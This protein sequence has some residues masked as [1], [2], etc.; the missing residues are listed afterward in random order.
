ME[1]SSLLMAIIAFLSV[2][3]LCIGIFDKLGFGTILG[4][5]FTGIILGPHTPELIYFDGVD[6]LHTIAEL[7]IVL[8]MF[9]VGLE[10]QP[11]KVWSMRK[12][13]FGLGS[14]QMLLTSICLFTIFVLGFGFN[15]SSSVIISLAC[16]MS[17]TAIIMASL[18]DSGQTRSEHGRATFS[19]LIAQ[20]MWIVPVMAL[21]PIISNSIIKQPTGPWYFKALTV[22]AVMFGILLIGNYVLPFILARLAMARKMIIF[23]SIVF[24]AILLTAW[25][26]EHVGISMTLGSFLL[27]VMLSASSYRFQI[28]SI[29]SPFKQLLMGLFFISVGMSI[30]INALTDDWTMILLIVP[31]IILVKIVVISVLTI[32]FGLSKSVAVRT[33]FY[34]SQVGEFSFVLLGAAKLAGLLSDAGQTLAMLVVATSMI[35]TP[36]LI[37]LGDCVANKM[38]FRSIN[39]EDTSMELQNHVV[40]VGYDEV[41]KLIGLMLDKAEIK[42]IA[43]DSDIEIVKSAK[44][45][46]QNVYY[47]NINSIVTQNSARLKNAAAI[48]ISG[49]DNDSA[50]ALAITFR[51]FFPNSEVFV[52]VATLEE[53]YELISRGVSNAHAIYV[54]G[55]LSSG[56]KLLK[57]LGVRE[58]EIAGII[59]DIQSSDY[60]EISPIGMR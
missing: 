27:G 30:E 35:L 52:C 39:Q 57:Y 26:F 5:I 33:G 51:E 16:A 23:A 48:Y 55:A 31:L 59:N 60:G 13:I 53:Q 6:E 58:S 22:S 12:L 20:D 8:F 14:T 37:K 56:V 10:M 3:V 41:G 43:L 49:R 29:V 17:S 54:D 24:L 36:L 32:S 47:A 9:S 4:F 45:S 18:E 46:H 11:Q 25:A 28:E 7:G 15:W 50:K 44:K 2:S 1:I 38:D 40:I 19:I 42:N 21:I 34:L